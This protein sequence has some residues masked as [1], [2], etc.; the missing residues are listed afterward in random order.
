M[1]INIFPHQTTLEKMGSFHVESMQ[2]FKRLSETIE[3]C[4]L[5]DL[6]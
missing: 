5:F 2:N 6:W 4:F 3:E 1:A